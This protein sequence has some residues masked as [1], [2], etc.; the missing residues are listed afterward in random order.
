MRVPES[1]GCFLSVKEWELCLKQVTKMRYNY[2]FVESHLAQIRTV[3]SEHLLAATVIV[4]CE[5]ARCHHLVAVR[6]C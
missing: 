4:L 5:V 3:T 6:S 1:P 2:Y